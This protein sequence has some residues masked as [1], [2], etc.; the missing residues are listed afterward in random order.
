[1]SGNAISSTRLYRIHSGMKSR[2]CNPNHQHYNRYGGRGIRVCDE[3]SGKD[4]AVRFIDWALSNGYDEGLTIDRIDPDGNYCPENCRWVSSS[5]NSLRT[6][7]RKGYSEA[8]IFI[9]RHT[10]E[11]MTIG[12]DGQTMV[13][14]LHSGGTFR[15]DPV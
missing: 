3:W 13:I 2:C 7:K 9:E 1:M 4:G 14:E 12:Y 8:Y 5:V 10:G 11:P 6:R 15:F